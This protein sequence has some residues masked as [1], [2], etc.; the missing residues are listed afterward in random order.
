MFMDGKQIKKTIYPNVYG[1]R[2]SNAHDV[3]LY[4]QLG[5]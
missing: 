4:V 5:P 1:I 2:Y 3:W